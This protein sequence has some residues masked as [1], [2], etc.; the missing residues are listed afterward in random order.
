MIGIG[1]VS[2]EMAL[3]DNSVIITVLCQP[4]PPLL[5]NI[6]NLSV[7]QQPTYKYPLLPLLV[8]EAS[9]AS[10]SVVALLIC[11]NQLAD[12]QLSYI[13]DLL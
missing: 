5:A 2:A 3:C 10:V 1:N 9:T 6:H 12:I 13:T 11:V 7:L 4:A 8:F